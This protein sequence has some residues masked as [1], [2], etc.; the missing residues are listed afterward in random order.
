MG[1]ASGLP[2]LFNSRNKNVF[3]QKPHAVLLL[4]RQEQMGIWSGLL[5]RHKLSVYNKSI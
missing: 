4:T 2:L 3:K 1:S 5:Q